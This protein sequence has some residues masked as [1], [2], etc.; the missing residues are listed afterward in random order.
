MEDV[1]KRRYSKVK[2]NDDEERR[3][4]KTLNEEA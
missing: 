1:A 2:D 4:D 3:D